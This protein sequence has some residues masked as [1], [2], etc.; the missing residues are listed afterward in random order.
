MS[1]TREFD[2]IVQGATGFTGKLTAEHLLRRYGA[3]GELRWALGGRNQ[4]KLESVRDQLAKETGVATAEL[5]IVI[6][7]AGDASSMLELARRAKVICSAVGPYAKYGSELVAACARE[8]TH[9]CDLTGEVHWIRRMIDAYQDDAQAS[10]ARIVHTCGFDCIPS[11]LGTFFVQREMLARHGVASPHVSLRVKGFSGAASGGTIASMMNMMEE[12]KTDPEILRTM[13]EPYSINPK[14]QRAGPDSAE[15]MR[16][17][18][19]EDFEQ[20]TAPF[21][22]AGVNTKV[23]R[24]SNALLGYA[25]GK[26]FRY[27]EALLTGT[28]ALGAAKAAATSAGTGG[29][30]LAFS[31][32]AVRKL[33]GGFLPA[34][35]DGPDQKTREAGYFDL[36]LLARHPSDRS[37]NVRARVTGDRDPGYGSTSKMLGEAAACLALDA[38][39]A[40]GGFHTPAS[41][42]G[43]A[44][45]ARLIEYAGLSFEVVES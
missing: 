42:M 4:K 44:L 20:W 41:A 34:P 28:G 6:G 1:D 19:D 2:V 11:D 30:M 7:D 33:L 27:D 26:D 29:A 5:P 21:V 45:L 18:Y 8:G 25:Y 36:R 12:S 39:D 16:P 31:L 24:R 17:A 35:G 13:N 22:M 38:L 37:K 9:Y 40:P 23:V 43:E 32:G 10:G 3:A 14:D 15:G